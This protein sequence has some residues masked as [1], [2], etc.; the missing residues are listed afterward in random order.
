MLTSLIKHAHHYS[1]VIM[2]AMSC[3]IT[4]LVILLLNRL[5]RL[6]SKK[7]SKLRVT[8]LCAGNAPVTG[9][10]P[11]QRTSSAENVSIWWRHHW[12]VNRKCRWSCQSL[13]PRSNKGYK[14]QRNRDFATEATKTGK[15]ACSYG[16]LN[17]LCACNKPILFNPYH[18]MI[19][20]ENNKV[21]LSS[22]WRLSYSL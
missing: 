3:Q 9:E 22:H 21:C 16:E 17:A 7:T 15:R 20:L 1:D 14:H 2:S 12:M 5:F 4:S 11:A 8:G 13:L 10:F 6:R 18:G 19:K